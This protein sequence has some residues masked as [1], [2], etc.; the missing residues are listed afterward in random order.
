MS[1]LVVPPE[2]RESYIKTIDSILAVSDLN[3][4]SEKRIRKGI[5]ETVNYDITP[6]KVSTP[7]NLVVLRPQF[8]SLSQPAIKELIME[9]FDIFAQK[10]GLGSAPSDQAAPSANGHDG[11][12]DG[13]TTDPSPQ[14]SSSPQKRQADSDEP[15]ENGSNTPPSK[16]RK[17]DHDIDADAL[18]AAKLQAEENKRARPTRNSATRKTAPVRKRAK[19]KTSKKVDDSDLES[20]SEAGAKK[21]VNRSGGFHVSPNQSLQYCIFLVLI[22]MQ[23]PL[24]LSPALSALLDGEVSVS[25]HDPMRE[26]LLLMCNSCLVHKLSNGCGSTSGR[27]G[28]RT[29][30]TAARFDATIE[31]ARSSNRIVCT[32]LP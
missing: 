17:P 8:H 6:Q 16:K 10:K 22:A 4:I 28:S 25:I 19:P 9:R 3:T 1:A 14:S 23:K 11:A 18:L 26:C 21:E 20:G 15:E 5:Q 27:T 31:C 30:L 12:A 24:T 13:Q 2:V 29:R 32:C 7:S